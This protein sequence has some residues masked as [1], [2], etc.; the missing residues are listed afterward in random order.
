MDKS[1]LFKRLIVVIIF[2]ILILTVLEFPAP[3]GFETRP[4]DNVSI[5]W[6]GFFLIILAS[7]LATIPLIFKSPKTGSIFGVVAGVLNILQVLADQF[8]LM[9][10]EIAPLSYRLLEYSMALLSCL[11][12]FFS[13]QIFKESVK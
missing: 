6:L 1:R 9:Q 12:I 5:L 10:P 11:L 2:L 4:Q 3:L 8:H 7:E 13:L